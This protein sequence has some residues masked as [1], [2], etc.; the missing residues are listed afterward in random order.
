MFIQRKHK[1]REHQMRFNYVLLIALFIVACQQKKTDENT[2]FIDELPKEKE[3]N[4]TPAKEASNQGNK[5]GEPIWG[6]RFVLVG[7]FNGDQIQDTLIEHFVDAQTK[8]ETNKFFE[9]LDIL[10][11]QG[12]EMLDHQIYSYMLTN[13][14][15]IDTF[16]YTSDLG[17]MYG[18]TIGDIDGDGGDEIGVVQYHADYSSV[19]TYSIYTYKNAWKLYYSFEVRD[20]EFPDLPEYNTVYGLF[21]A[22]GKTLVSDSSQNKKIEQELKVYRRVNIVAPNTI[23]Y[24]AFDIGDCDINYV[25]QAYEDSVLWVV[26]KFPIQD[27]N[28][29]SVW[30]EYNLYS[31]DELEGIKTQKEPIEICD[32]AS[33]GRQRV[34]FKKASPSNHWVQ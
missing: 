9:N 31:D 22:M 32:P 21:G 27:K 12:D 4:S 7:D 8:A 2:T 10:N 28:I 34:K 29:V 33:E 26:P 15:A 14:L 18:E 23:Q 1:N 13:T 25:Y 20:W 24:A 17:I 3:D 16:P 5:I 6:Y 19:N 11:Y 30:T